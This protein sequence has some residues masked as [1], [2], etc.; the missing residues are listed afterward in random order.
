MALKLLDWEAECC[1]KSSYVWAEDVVGSVTAVFGLVST[2]SDFNKG[3]NGL[4][5]PPWPTGHSPK[6]KLAGV[7]R[8]TARLMPPI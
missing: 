2:L 4:Q 5:Q 3:G 6:Q 7:L 8:L 1:L